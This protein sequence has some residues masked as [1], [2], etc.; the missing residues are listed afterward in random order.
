M[1]GQNTLEITNTCNDSQPDQPPNKPQ[2]SKAHVSLDQS[3]LEFLDDEP[4]KSRA[5]TGQSSE[6]SEQEDRKDPQVEFEQPTDISAN[7]NKYTL[8]EDGS[9][10]IQLEDISNVAKDLKTQAEIKDKKHSKLAQS[11]AKAL[12]L[13]YH[14]N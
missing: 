6:S 3:H 14:E 11:L 9:C 10:S 1:N 2:D 4:N 8:P 12:Q 7:I 13:K 5:H